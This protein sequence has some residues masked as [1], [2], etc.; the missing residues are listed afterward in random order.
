VEAC[1]PADGQCKGT[2]LCAGVTC[3]ASDLCHL[4]GICDPSTGTCSTQTYKSC[5][6]GQTCDP[7]DGQCK[8]TNLCAGVTCTASDLCHLPGTC[9]PSTGTCSTQTS[10]TCSTGQTCDPTDGQCKATNLCAGVICTASDLCHLPGTCDPSTGTCSSQTSKT[11]PTGQTCDPTD[12][13]CKASSGTVLTPQAAQNEGVGDQQG[14]ALDL[15]G[16]AYVT[17]FFAGTI[18]VSG[19]QLVSAG[20][21]DLMVAK[22]GPNSGTTPGAPLWVKSYGDASEQTPA[23]SQH[24]IAA[25][26]DGTAVV[27]G[28]FTGTV[29]PG[30][31]NPNSY[32]IDFLIGFNGT[33][34]AVAWSKV[35]NNGVNGRFFAVAANPALNLVAVCGHAS[36]ASDF[37]PGATFAGG[38]DDIVIGM[39][40]SA[41]TFQWARQIGGAQEEECDSIA[42][43]DVGNLY[44]AGKYD[45]TLNFCTGANGD[46]VGSALPNPNSSF[47]KWLWLAKFNGTTGAAMAQTS[48]GSGAG[49]HLVKGLAVTPTGVA[50]AG[51]Y[52]NS[53]PIGTTTLGPAVGSSDA[54]VARVDFTGG[55][56]VP[57]WAVAEGSAGVDEFRGI[58]VDSYGN[59]AVTGIVSGP[60]TGM[61]ALNPPGTG[62]AMVLFSLNGGTGAVSSSAI[63]GNTLGTAVAGDGVALNREATGSLQNQVVITGDYAQSVTFP[64]P[65]GMLTAPGSAAF[66]IWAPLL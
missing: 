15:N 17:S 62:A 46:C 9:D 48:F 36:Q 22:Y 64:A 4:P 61:A 52:S 29:V 49:S 32:K 60:S 31:S 50:L 2:N 42:I 47:R 41:G 6:T 25:T 26:L 63:Y 35:V 16:N 12:G 65:V 19:T 33:N 57:K 55:T 37:V 34:G 11:C 24:S 66:V 51:S 58:G 18:T 44:A 21:S 39:F 45:G 23:T 28:G 20:A 30:A 43:D 7:T 53:L 13:Q 14:V 27:V 54:F 56:F 10:K 5:P 59:Y 40:N 3:T 1:D 38:Q 8:A